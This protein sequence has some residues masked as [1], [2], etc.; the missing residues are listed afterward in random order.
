[1]ALAI[2]ALVIV[3][4]RGP[5]VPVVM[6]VRKPLVHRVVASGR[7]MPPARMHLGSTLMGK[8]VSVKVREGDQVKLGDLLIQLDDAE[9]KAAVA[10]AR[11]SVS[12]AAARLSVVRQV[13]SRLATE[14]LNQAN[15]N[16]EQADKQ[17]KRIETLLQSGAVPQEELDNAH[18]A[19]DNARSQHTSAATQLQSTGPSGSDYLVSLTSVS[20]AQAGL[21]GALARLEQTRIV[22]PAD[23]VVLTRA[24]E[25]GDVVQP[26]KVMM[27]LAQ[28]GDT[29][30]L[31]TP[32]EKNL[33]FLRVGQ[34]AL[35]SADAFADDRFD[36][37]IVFIAPGVDPNRGT[38]EVKLK[39]DKPPA[40]LRADMTVSVDV[41]V[42]RRSDAMV[43][44][45][46]AVRDSAGDNPWVLV[47]RGN[48]LE[49]KRVKTGIRGEGV[50]E[51][52]EGIEAGELVVPASAGPL[53]PGN[54]VRPK[55]SAKEVSGAV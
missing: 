52:V 18:R 1:V 55:A 20:Q 23:G 4:V 16:L 25:P 45:T 8:A 54:R 17:F 34:G 43:L 41:E 50:V 6:A 51:I 32:D 48:R 35:A 46:E 19:L 44:P 10:Q 30:L 15:S 9:A 11:A 38:I 21:Q 13:T 40:Y 33:A 26:G 49:R 36:S 53:T 7:V 31:V 24:V 29:H 5:Q 28:A 27:I 12:Q 14:T 3:K 2:A 37:R 42:G 47:V 22:A 39:V